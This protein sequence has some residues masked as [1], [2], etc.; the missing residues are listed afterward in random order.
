MESPGHLKMEMAIF[1]TL[2]FIYKLSQA[3]AQDGELGTLQGHF[4]IFW[5]PSARRGGFNMRAVD[6][7][8]IR[9]GTESRQRAP[10]AI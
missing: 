5:M 8:R 2:H 7:G 10:S 6:G 1:Q 9:A 3:L 4:Q